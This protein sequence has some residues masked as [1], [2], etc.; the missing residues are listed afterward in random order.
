V[1]AFRA[2]RVEHKIVKIPKNEVAVTLGRPEATAASGVDLEKDLAIHQQGEK[3]K[4]GKIVP[5]T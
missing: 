5:P 3:L 2:A 4:S 1:S